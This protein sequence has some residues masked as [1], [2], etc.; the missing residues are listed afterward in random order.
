ML[1][2][3]LPFLPVACALVAVSCEKPKVEMP[4]PVVTYTTLGKKDVTA[5][6]SWVGLLD[7]YQNANIQ[8]QVT[9]YLLT[10][11]Y[12]EGS[13]VKKGT[14]LFTID[15]RPFQAALAQA[16]ADYAKAVAQAQL[17]EI[18]LERQAQLYKTKVISQQEYDTVYQ[19]A[20]AAVASQA[21]AQAAVQAAQVNLDYCTV[22]APFDGVAGIAQ[23]QIGDLVGPGGRTSILTQVSQ[24]D[25]MK[26]NFSITESEYLRAAKLLAELQNTERSERSSG[27]MTLRLADGEE[28]PYKG[29]FDFVNRQVSSS[30]GTIQITGLFPNPDGILRPGLFARVTAP[31]EEIKDAFVVPQEAIAEL[32]GNHFVITLTPDNTAKPVFVKLG[33][34]DGAMQVVKG[35]LV[36]GAK[37][38][39]QGVE[40][41]RPGTKV[42]A[43]P[44]KAPAPP[45]AAPSASPEPSATPAS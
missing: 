26:M 2:K 10:Q 18:T 41:A 1:R 45:A 37:I 40:K 4:L 36:E 27:R 33:P 14:V 7:G 11:N 28:Y 38:V 43:S 35:D 24:I 32:Q 20:Q 25:P 5:T 42:N 44:Y 30:T 21:A 13:V 15:P 31:V 22:V 3:L 23:A 9:G 12:K 8:A 39:V 29:A 19:N 16:Q 34:V 6:S 17:Q